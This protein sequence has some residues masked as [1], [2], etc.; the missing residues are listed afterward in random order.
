MKNYI[1]LIT[2]LFGIITAYIYF[3]QRDTIQRLTNNIESLTID[4][5]T[6][7]VLEK[8]EL[9]RL[10]YYKRELDSLKINPAKVKRI[11]VTNVV[12]KTDTFET[13]KTIETVKYKD[14]DYSQYTTNNGCFDVNILATD[15]PIL[16]PIEF[17]LKVKQFE[18]YRRKKILFLRIGRQYVE[19]KITSNCG[20]VKTEVI[21]VLK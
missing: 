5:N 17:E 6:Y 1:I 4:S 11:T 15:E 14:K 21:E 16:L 20:E 10:Q 2:C 3:K 13:V 8:R 18:Y 12:V 9:K 19:T 7:I